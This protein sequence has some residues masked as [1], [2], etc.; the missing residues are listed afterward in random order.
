MIPAV[1]EST[2]CSATANIRYGTALPNNAATAMWPHTRPARGTFSRRASTI[3][4]SATAPRTSR[5]RVTSTGE[6]PRSASLIHR[7]ADPQISASKAIRGSAERV[8]TA[9]SGVQRVDQGLGD[10]FGGG[11]AAQVAGE[12]AG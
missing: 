5:A 8:T 12:D 3:T 9:G 1:E 4:N 10:V 2:C 11:G 6:N 7:N